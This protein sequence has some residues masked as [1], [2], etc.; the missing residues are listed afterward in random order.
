MSEALIVPCLS[1]GTLNRVPRA[2]LG[3]VPVCADCRAP[4]LDQPPR[5]VGEALFERLLEKSD[6]P[7]LVDFWAEWCGP[8]R[9]MGPQF[10]AAATSLRGRALLVKVDTEAEPRIAA[11]FGIQSIPT[12]IAFL[13]GRQLARQSGALQAAQIVAWFE[14]L[15]PG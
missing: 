15:P 8:C 14:R 3:E 11:H 2:R 6:L 4:L 9:V 7:V 10:A 1:C 13:H 5:D 12:M